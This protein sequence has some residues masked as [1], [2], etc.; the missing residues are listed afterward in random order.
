MLD[1]PKSHFPYVIAITTG[2]E[3]KKDP[4][5][6]QSPFAKRFKQI[7]IQKAPKGEMLKI[8]KSKLFAQAPGLIVEKEAFLHEILSNSF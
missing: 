2:E 5:L 6:T 1:D 7:D 8:L 4:S 3:Y